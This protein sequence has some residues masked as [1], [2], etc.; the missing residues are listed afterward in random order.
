[1]NKNHNTAWPFW[2]VMPTVNPLG[3][4]KPKRTRADVLAEIDEAAEKIRHLTEELREFD[5]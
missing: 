4:M 1:M 5:E 2:P 3:M